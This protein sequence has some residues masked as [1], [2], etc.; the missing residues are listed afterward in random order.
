MSF[1]L[2]RQHFGCLCIWAALFFG[3]LVQKLPAQ[4]AIDKNTSPLSNK[5]KRELDQVVFPAIQTGDDVT[6]YERFGA[7]V[8]NQKR[9]VVNAIEAY[10]SENKIESPLKRL[11]DLKLRRIEQGIDDPNEKFNLRQALLLIEG[12]NR[13]VAS[14]FNSV[15]DH[16]FLQEHIGVPRDW[17][18]S[19]DL[20]WET[21]VMRNEF[22]N[23]NKILNYGN[24]V[25][26][27]IKARLKN[28]D[29]QNQQVVDK[30]GELWERFPII[31]KELVEGEAVARLTR[32]NRAI[33]VLKKD[34][35][36]EQQF[37][38]AM[39]VELDSESLVP[40][41]ASASSIERK[42]LSNP[43]LAIDI[44][45]TVSALRREKPEL[46]KK[47]QLFRSG[48]HWWLRGRYGM[49]TLSN[50][51][52]KAKT[53]IQSIDQMNSVYMPRN[54]PVPKNDFIG[55]NAGDETQPFYKRRHYY[56]WAVEY[57]PILENYGRN[58]ERSSR[59]EQKLISRTV[60]DEQYRDF[61]L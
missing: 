10:A 36:F 26:G 9:T 21:H 31:R 11:V 60:I 59:P 56:T 53:A 8:S 49:G 52:L 23:Y 33:T 54:R 22:S 44:Q 32:F 14:F 3:G 25:L 42:E 58:V 34:L 20:F 39:N 40:F 43:A 51:L 45:N 1:L 48:S 35:N 55:S 24:E 29:A 4:H 13:R 19:R 28:T 46:M 2:V 7:V 17:K 37:I 38:A 47:A 18:K 15:S 41:F 57:R 16:P 6:F 12:I 27:S 5:I 30:F 50:G 61:F